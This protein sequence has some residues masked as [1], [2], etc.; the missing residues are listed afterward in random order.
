MPA[1]IPLHEFPVP[2]PPPVAGA[3]AAATLPMPTGGRRPPDAS[4]FV[5]VGEIKYYSR[6]RRFS[7]FCNQMS[8][9]DRCR[10]ERTA[11]ASR[12]GI[13]GQGRPLGY[14]V[15]WL[16]RGH[17]HETQQE[18]MNCEDCE[19]AISLEDRSAARERL[20]QTLGFEGLF[21]GERP[22]RDGEDDEPLEHP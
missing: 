13:G 20:Q 5:D 2:P 8:H 22:R 7:A 4:V 9:G 19:V 12:S 15:A 3:M 6:A 17:Q 18:H 14:L 11:N 16:S 1:A 21:A 10:R